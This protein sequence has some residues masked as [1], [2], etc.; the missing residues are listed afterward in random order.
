MEEL[1]LPII[2]YEGLYDVSNLGR[3]RNSRTNKILRLGKHRQGYK[4]V[5][6]YKNKK[7]KTLLV[8]RLVAMAFIEN[9]HSFFRNKPYR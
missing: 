9:P 7:E 3:I 8:H 1:W 6:L 5:S 4:L 2:G